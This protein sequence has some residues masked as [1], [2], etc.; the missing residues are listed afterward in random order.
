MKIKIENLGVVQE[1]PLTRDGHRNPEWAG[2]LLPV[3]I[4]RMDNTM[5][6]VESCGKIHR[7]GKPVGTVDRALVGFAFVINLTDTHGPRGE[8]LSYTIDFG[9][10]INASLELVEQIAAVEHVPLR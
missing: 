8:R 1:I 9:D 7:D 3:R 10:A 5:G 2:V 6:M 4:N